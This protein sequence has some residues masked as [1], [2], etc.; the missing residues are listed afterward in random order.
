MRARKIALLSSVLVMPSPEVTIVSIG[1][2]VM[3][4]TQKRPL[5]AHVISTCG[6]DMRSGP[7][8]KYAPV[9]MHASC[10]GQHDA[11]LAY[12]THVCILA[13]RLYMGA[14]KCLWANKV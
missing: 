5:R 13:Y 9:C 10:S 1:S 2:V 11:V 6:P 12:I 7:M 8:G 14:C 3:R 4:S